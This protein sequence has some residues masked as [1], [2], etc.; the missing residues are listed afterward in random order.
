VE[1]EVLEEGDGGDEGG[2]GRLA[3]RDGGVLGVGGNF[4]ERYVLYRRHLLLPRDELIFLYV[5]SA[6]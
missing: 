5:L 6:S 4:G 3:A 2:D 1:V